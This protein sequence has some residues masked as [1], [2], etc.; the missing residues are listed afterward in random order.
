MSN[1]DTNWLEIFPGT[2]AVPPLMPPPFVIRGGVPSSFDEKHL[3]PN[4]RKP[5]IS[6]FIGR[7]LKLSSPVNI[8]KPPLV[9]DDIAAIIL[10]V[11]PEFSASMTFSG[12]SKQSRPFIDKISFS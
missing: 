10:I 6:G 12:T 1:E 2:F 3:T 8:V 9:K 11:V 4:C 5:R 7:L